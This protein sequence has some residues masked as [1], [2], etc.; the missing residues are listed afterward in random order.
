MSIKKARGARRVKLDWALTFGG[1]VTQ[2]ERDTIVSMIRERVPSVKAVYLFGSRVN[3][4]G[5][6]V[7]AHSDWDIAFF[8]EF[9]HVL[10][11]WDKPGLHADLARAL[12]AE[13]VDLIDLGMEMDCV[14]FENV[15]GGERLWAGDED[16]VLTWELGREGVVRDW[17]F[18]NKGAHV[19][20][21][22][23]IRERVGNHRAKKSEQ[24]A[25]MSAPRS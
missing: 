16:V 6:Y 8:A 23:E 7:N 2:Q 4:D 9:E 12:E 21:I 5:A 17:R 22:D 18:R 14:L 25:A 19:E 13:H 20:E 11:G 15:M 10:E 3:H 1:M 24:S